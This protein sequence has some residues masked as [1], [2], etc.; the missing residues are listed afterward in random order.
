MA[1]TAQCQLSELPRRARCLPAVGCSSLLQPVL[2]DLAG[3]IG[4]P[5]G[6]SLLPILCL[7][8]CTCCRGERGRQSVSS[9]AGKGLRRALGPG[10][11]RGDLQGCWVVFIDWGNTRSRG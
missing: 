10:R 6:Q 11:Q 9:V 3:L 7:L 4:A 1:L 8:V 5:T 2:L